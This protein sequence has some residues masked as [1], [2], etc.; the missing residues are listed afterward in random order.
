MVCVTGCQFK[1]CNPL[2]HSRN[3]YKLPQAIQCAIDWTYQNKKDKRPKVP[4][5][6]LTASSRDKWDQSP[7]LDNKQ[8]NAYNHHHN[9][10]THTHTHARINNKEPRL[11]LLSLL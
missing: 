5:C 11:I 2:I 3:T 10:Y 7:K 8:V 1:K 9:C 4:Y 6:T